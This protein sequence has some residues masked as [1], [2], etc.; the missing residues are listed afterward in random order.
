MSLNRK[1]NVIAFAMTFLLG[2]SSGVPV[3]ITNQSGHALQNVTISGS[4]FQQHVSAIPAGETA[5]LYVQPKGESGIAIRFDMDGGRFTYAENGYFESQ[6]Y[7]V[8][9]VVDTAGKASVRTELA[10]Y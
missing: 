8:D 5:T 9:I 7:R 6:G 1:N 4:G 2:C 10:H 3:A